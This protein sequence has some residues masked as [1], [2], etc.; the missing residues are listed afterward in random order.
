[1][2]SIL[3]VYHM[4]LTMDAI[5][6]VQHQIV[7]MEQ[8]GDAATASAIFKLSDVACMSKWHHSPYYMVY[9]LY[10][11][12]H[13]KVMEST[14]G[15]LKTPYWGRTICNFPFLSPN[16]RS[17]R[18]TQC[19]WIGVI[20]EN[21]ALHWDLWGPRTPNPNDKTL[22]TNAMSNICWDLLVPTY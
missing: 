20:L 4:W 1:M 19:F 6:H 15:S 7:T 8:L 16:H 21:V 13:R 3:K 2:T 18:Q 9:I 14:H 22:T 5:L 10:C 11:K 17:N 12:K